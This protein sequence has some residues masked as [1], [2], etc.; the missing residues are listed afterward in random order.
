MKKNRIFIVAIPVLIILFGLVIYQYVYLGIQDQLAA[1][2][3]EQDVKAKTLQKYQTVI[4]EGPELQKKL[5]ALRE[6]RKT[7]AV[8]FIQGD[9]FSLAAAALQEIIKGIIT[10]RSG[11][12]SSER[13]GKEEDLPL[14]SAGQ[15]KEEPKAPKGEKGSKPKKEKPEEKRRFKV[16]SVSFDFTAPDAGAL[17]DI[18]FFIETRT[19]YLVIKEL[20][21]RVR[22]FQQPRELMVRLD[23]SAL[24]GGK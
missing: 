14:A 10:S 1:I 24:Y 17:R 8:K 18:V 2:R 5:L 22:N 7:E 23:V 9:S 19:P 3:E 15:P 4:A 16:I 21:C 11:V 12:I 6:Q 20:D 13:V